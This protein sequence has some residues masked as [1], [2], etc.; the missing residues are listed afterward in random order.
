MTNSFRIKSVFLLTFTTALLTLPLTTNAKSQKIVTKLIHRDSIF[1]PFY[2]LDD[3]IEDRALR[4]L[5]NSNSRFAH[6]KAK[7]KRNLVLDYYDDDDDDSGAKIYQANLLANYGHLFV[8]NISIGQPPIPQLLY[9]DT[10]STLPWIQCKQ[11]TKCLKQQ[12]P[13]YDP[14]SSSTYNDLPCGDDSC[15]DFPGV[16]VSCG[17]LNNCIYRIQYMDKSLSKGRIGTE[18]IIFETPDEGKVA[19]RDVVFG[20]GEE[21]N[22]SVRGLGVGVFGLGYSNFVINLG[23]VF[24]YCIGSVRDPQYGFNGLTFGDDSSVEGYSTPFEV[25]EGT[26]YI[27]LEGISVGQERLDIS[28]DVFK[29]TRKGGGAVIDS[30]SELTYLPEVAFNLLKSKVSSILNGFLRQRVFENAQ[31]MLCYEGDLS[32]DLYG[33]PATTFHFSEGADLV[34]ETESLFAQDTKDVFCVAVSHLNNATTQP[35]IIGILAQQYYNVAYDLGAKRIYFQRIDCE[36]L[37]D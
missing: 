9:M 2:N 10:G 25:I 34:L 21:N 7:A 18:Q 6:L 35:S 19:V 30:G 20:C 12:G 5:K 28:P 8:V 17:E 31:H 11:C 3:G 23:L 1:S 29:R 26:Y 24:S 27:T 36:L 33:F 13:V 32:R 22:M 4:I 16:N 15:G 37:Y 14:S